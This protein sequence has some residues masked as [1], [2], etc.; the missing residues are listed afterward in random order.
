MK[1]ARLVDVERQQIKDNRC[2][3]ASMGFLKCHRSGSLEAEPE[4]GCSCGR[5][6]RATCRGA[7]GWER[8]GLLS[9][10]RV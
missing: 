7:V 4:T 8:E 10:H 2:Q 3:F 6:L 5:A 9:K 1:L